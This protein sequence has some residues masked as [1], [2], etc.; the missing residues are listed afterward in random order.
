MMP[1]PDAIIPKSSANA[2][3]GRCDLS[4]QD[5]I[6]LGLAPIVKTV[7]SLILPAP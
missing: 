4:R 6:L 3:G 2:P 5:V 7:S 1:P